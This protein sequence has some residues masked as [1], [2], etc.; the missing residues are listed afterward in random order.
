[1]D[2]PLIG[3]LAWGVGK[4][5]KEVVNTQARTK[6]LMLNSHAVAIMCVLFLRL[7][8]SYCDCLLGMAPRQCICCG[9]LWAIP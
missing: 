7:N 1:M 6:E 4:M 2:I 9:A 3:V 8:T 5:H